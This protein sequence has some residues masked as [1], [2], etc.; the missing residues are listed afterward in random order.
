MAEV[1]VRGVD[2]DWTVLL[3]EARRVDLPTYAFNR[4]RYWLD[5]SVR[6]AAGA[7]SG[8]GLAPADHPLLGAVVG[9]AADGG[10][11]FT[12][13]ISRTTHPWLADHTVGTAVLLP[14]TALVEIVLRAGDEVGCDVL[15]ELVTEAPLVLPDHGAVQLQVT[16]AA[17]DPEGRRS[18]EVHSRPESAGATSWT[19]HASGQLGGVHPVP[20]QTTGPWP[21]HGAEPV[22]LTGFYQRQAEAGY[23]YGPA[24]QGL[25]ALWRLGDEVLA[26]VALPEDRHTDA[27]AFGL[28]PALLDA[29]LHAST[30]CASSPQSPEDGILLP[31]AWQDVTLYASG[32]T[33]LRVRCTPTAPNTVELLLTDHADTPVA[34]IGSLLTRPI[35]RSRLD[36]GRTAPDD[37]LFTVQWSR[38]A[39]AQAPDFSDWAVVG[40]ATLPDAPATYPDV[41]ALTTA[42]DSGRPV[43]GTALIEIG[44]RPGAT[45]GPAAAALEALRAWLAEP[46]LDAVRLVVLTHGAMA[47]HPIEKVDPAVAAVWGLV[48]SA[49]SEHP[50]RFTLLDRDSRDVS[51]A[52]LAAAVATGEP[53]LALRAGEAWTP[54]LVRAE[55]A[56]EL[57]VPAG[58]PAWCLAPTG[59]AT[60][61]G[62]TLIPAPDALA[63]LDRG[64]VRVGVRAAG[65]NFRDVLVALDMVPGQSGLGGEA[66]GV[67]L[68]VGPDVS[69]LA[70]GDRV[71]GTFDQTFG[72]FGPVA[73][74]DHRLLAAIPA[75][76]SFAQA[77]SVPIAY[78]TAYYALRD[79]A[80]VG[81][82]D[83]VLIHSATGGVGT[84]AVRLAR[85][86]GAE[87]FGTAGPGKRAAL[88]ELGLDD[89]HIASSR[90]V[91]F[92]SDFLAATG[93]LGMDVVLN[94]LAGEFTDASLR[95]LARG[96]R[97]LEMGKTDVRDGAEVADAHP[98]ADYRAFDLRQAGPDRIAQMLSELLVLFERG[99]LQLPPLTT[100]DVRRA[101]E[102][103]GHISR[104][105]HIG[106]VVLTVPHS[107]DPVGTV[108][109]TGGTGVLGRLVVR[110]LVVVHGVRRLVVVSRSGLGAQG[111]GEW[112]AELSG[113]GAVVD[114][115]V[116]DVSDRGVVEGVVAGVGVE[117]PLVGVV[118]LAGVLDDGVFSSLGPE[119]LGGVFGP[120]ADAAVH[121]DELTRG[122]DLSMFVV[123]SSA[124]GVFGNPG[125]ANYAAANAFVDGLVQRRR[126]E[127]L[128]GVSMAWGLW[129][130]TSGLTAHLGQTDHRRTRRGGMVGLTSA[131]GMALFD[132]ALRSDVS[133]LV[134]TRLDLGVL[135]SAD[136]TEPVPVLLSGLARRPRPVA[137][138]QRATGTGLAA[139]LAVLSDAD[140]DQLLV[141]LVCSQA[142]TVLGHSGGDAIPAD[143][144]F[145]ESG[146]DSLTSVELRNRLNTAT[147]L[148]LPTTIVFDHPTPTALARFV[149]TGLTG[150][151]PAPAA[152]PRQSR[153]T[154]EPIAIVGMGCRFPGGVA[155]PE[156]LWRLVAGGGEVLSAFPTDRGW[157][158]E[159]LFDA[160]PDRAGTSYV[161]V[162]GFLEDV[163]G[164]DAG[165]FGIS[166]REAVA[167]D[168][169]QR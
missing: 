24:F 127:G 140:A 45:T 21:P 114:V 44:A 164:F 29:A 72:A 167:M 31:F 141:D 162:G 52:A 87:V 169:Q 61:D 50:D 33:E 80:G 147:G 14:G 99:A 122:C 71:M 130:E 55:P 84:A 138:A 129:E 7:A 107:L 78:L 161:R 134:P 25:R 93:G 168:P 94:S 124:S 154:D 4:Q 108:L 79:L 123:F 160:D 145:K 155:S 117:H 135:R 152:A 90:S 102:A 165:F 65:V 17:P 109:V 83:R 139:R 57:C 148:R 10:S 77:A 60:V 116:G 5:R 8:I 53:Q 157:D 73:V 150:A 46:R 142:A 128:P 132:A 112:V 64:Q 22:D 69:G 16:V 115:V 34:S 66:S 101:P 12:G 75:D 49:Q 32:A 59:T 2:V 58:A 100:W 35:E 166:P 153:P 1:H 159:A 76:W 54:R 20:P 146:F 36:P 37:A 136:R 91:R 68:E 18:V 103:F 120:K 111:V 62:L 13:R 144:A 42:L 98:G 27:T 92:G 85:H 143:R 105:D 119:R 30:F 110:H 70:P 151:A 74:T 133:V 158:L 88:H 3:P 125:Q 86:L 15:E 41:P 121:L 39:L 23:V 81:P 11:L 89:A 163:A 9:L 56:P 26:E 97:F 48:R 51:F 137:A 96:G 43:P 19:R 82:G 28:H 6:N 104:A 38:H 47:V 106:K 40:A 67:V 95:L 113:L 126:A 156:D 149:R 63:P 118:H 131:E